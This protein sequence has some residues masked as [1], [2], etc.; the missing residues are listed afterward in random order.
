MSRWEATQ[1]WEYTVEYG[2]SVERLNELGAQGWELVAVLGKDNIWSTRNTGF[3]F[4]RR[5]P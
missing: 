5:K 4:K 1:V 3:Y 2:C